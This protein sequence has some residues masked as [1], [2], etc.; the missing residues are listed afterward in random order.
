MSE[1]DQDRIEN[2]QKQLADM[3]AE[4]ERLRTANL[5]VLN[6]QQ[7]VDPLANIGQLPGNAQ[8]DIATIATYKLP[9]FWKSKP[10]LW[11]TQIESIFRKRNVRTERTKYDAVM[12]IL[13]QQA[14]DEISDI[15]EQP[16]DEQ[17]YTRLKETLIKRFSESSERQLHRLLS[18]IELGDK[19]PS[20]LLRKMR[21][22]GKN[23]ATDSLLRTKWMSLLP[24]N[25][26][27]ILLVAHDVDLN[28][29]AEMADKLME[30]AGGCV[31]AVNTTNSQGDCAIKNSADKQHDERLDK[32]EKMISD[33]QISIKELLRGCCVQMSRTMVSKKPEPPTGKLVTLSSTVAGG[34]SA[35]NRELRLHVYDKTTDQKFLI[36]SGSVVSVIPRTTIKN[37][38]SQTS[39]K[40]Y[41]ANSTVINTYGQRHITLNLG[42][43]RDIDWNF[44]IADVKSP[45]TGADLIAHHGLLFDLKRRRLIDP[46]TSLE[47]LGELKQASEYGISTLSDSQL[48]QN[49]Y[50]QKYKDLLEE[51]IDIRK[52]RTRSRKD[53]DPKFAHYIHTTGQP[54]RERPR[55]LAGEKLEAAQ[56]EINKMLKEGVIRPSKSP[57]ASPIL[58]RPKKSDNYSPPS[59]QNLIQLPPETTVLSV[60]DMEKA[61]SLTP[62]AEEHVERTAITTP[63]GLFEHLYSP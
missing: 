1:T 46:K 22:L 12:E 31:T 40:L 19:K 13:D 14:V 11:F 35:I 50:S 62:V 59:I 7:V 24:Q 28:K 26:T 44:I 17:S 23:E 58:L 6:Q 39:Q 45:I 55:K 60:Y 47:V 4:M 33:I 21:N 41:A 51:F 5:A 16:V 27:N 57:W 15:I 20:Q 30:F 32:I 37:K 49:E 61:Y 43:R 52:P 56:K 9:L 54:V 38:A 29:L 25:V 53:I 42:V 48:P 36:D 63:F 3:Q 18:E 34:D 10:Q 8:V 2:L